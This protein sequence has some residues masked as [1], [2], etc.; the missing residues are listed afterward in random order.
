MEGRSAR[1]N[2]AK[3]ANSS[4]NLTHL[5][6]MPCKQGTKWLDFTPPSWSII[7]ITWEPARGPFVAHVR[8]LVG[9]YLYGLTSTEQCVGVESCALHR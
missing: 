6:S 3:L 8:Y 2:G 5:E 9:P 4:V 1:V 7:M